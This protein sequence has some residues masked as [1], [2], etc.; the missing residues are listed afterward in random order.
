MKM[1]HECRATHIL[2]VIFMENSM[3]PLILDLARGNVKVKPKW[4]PISR[5]EILSK[6]P[7]RKPT[8]NHQELEKL[9][10]YN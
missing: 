1:L 5:Q 9:V 8:P 2:W 4:G 10:D 3:M 7:Y 6:E